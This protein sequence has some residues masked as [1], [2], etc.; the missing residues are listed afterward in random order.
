MFEKG[1]VKDSSFKF[2]TTTTTLNCAEGKFCV[3]ADPSSKHHFR[4][5]KLA[6]S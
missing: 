6:L 5:F 3:T 2:G 1:A 4:L